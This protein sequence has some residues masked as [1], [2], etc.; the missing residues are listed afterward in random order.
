M[1]CLVFPAI[2]AEFKMVLW[3]SV[4]VIVPAFCPLS[5]RATKVNPNILLDA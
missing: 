2:L 5:F 1:Y 3:V 4:L